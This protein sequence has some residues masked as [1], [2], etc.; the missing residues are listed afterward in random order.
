[1][2]RKELKEI[3]GAYG[4]D[5]MTVPEEDGSSYVNEVDI[6]GIAGNPEEEM[7]ARDMQIKRG[8]NLSII[9]KQPKDKPLD[10]TKAKQ[11]KL[12]PL[13]DMFIDDEDAFFAKVGNDEKLA[14]DLVGLARKTRPGWFITA[15]KQAL[16]LYNK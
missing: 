15:L 7:A 3:T 5:A 10:Q 14:L 8:K 1:M 16:N 13:L 9:T 11:L 12:E 6:Y 2:I 4:G